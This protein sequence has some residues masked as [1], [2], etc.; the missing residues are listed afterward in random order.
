MY[1]VNI[2]TKERWIYISFDEWDSK[3]PDSFVRLI[4]AYKDKLSGKIVAASEEMQYKI[5][6][7]DLG[8]MFQWDGCFGMTVV[9][10]DKTDLI[11]A[12]NTLVELCE[13]LN[14]MIL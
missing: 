14:C 2:P 9:V 11:K 7:D 10:P 4:K 5:D 13:T 3:E 6:N 8:L 1:S 12:Y